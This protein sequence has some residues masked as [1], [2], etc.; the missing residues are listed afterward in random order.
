MGMASA[1]AV[2]IF[3][4]VALVSGISFARTRMLEEVSR[5]M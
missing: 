5:G 4:I 2:N 1:L 3:L